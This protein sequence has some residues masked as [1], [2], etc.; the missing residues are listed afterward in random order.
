MTLVAADIGCFER[1]GLRDV[2]GIDGDDTRPFGVRRQHHGKRFDFANPEDRSE[3][4]GDELT[5]RVIVV[6]KDDFMEVRPFRFWPDLGTRT[7][8]N[9]VHLSQ[10]RLWRRGVLA[11]YAF[12]RRKSSDLGIVQ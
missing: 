8:K 4:D 7:V 11:R 9:C 12:A 10:F 1:L 2:L 5:R 6:E 3:H